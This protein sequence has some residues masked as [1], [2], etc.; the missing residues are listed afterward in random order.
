MTQGSGKDQQPIF[1]VTKDMKRMVENKLKDA[2]FDITKG[3]M[4]PVIRRMSTHE[5]TNLNI[6]DSMSKIHKRK[7][8]LDQRYQ[9]L[10]NVKQTNLNMLDLIKQSKIDSQMNYDGL[11]DKFIKSMNSN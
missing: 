4:D 11:F 5:V 1:V 3:Q 8:I 9:Q 10:M 7:A 6:K 2:N